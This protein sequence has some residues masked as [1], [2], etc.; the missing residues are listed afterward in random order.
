[1]VN[2]AWE[3]LWGIKLE[4]LTAYN[5]LEDKQL[6]EKGIMSYIK[7][8]FQGT[9]THIPAIKYEPNE[10][11]KDSTTVPFRWVEAVIYPIKD[12]AGKIIEIVLQHTDITE[13]KMM[14]DAL[15]KSEEKF[16]TLIENSSDAIAVV[17]EQGIITYI[18]ETVTHVLGYKPK[19]LMNKNIFEYIHPDDRAHLTEELGDIVKNKAQVTVQ[20][21]NLHKNGTW[22]WL[23]ATGVNYMDKPGINGILGNFRDITE[24]KLAE[25]EL[26]E[27]NQTLKTIIKASP[28]AVYVVDRTGKVILWSKVAEKMFGWSEKEVKGKVLPIVQSD[29]KVEFQELMDTLLKGKSFT[30]ETTR[31]HKDG[32]I[33]DVSISAAPVFDKNGEL[34]SIVAIT[35]D[36]TERKKTEEALRNSEERLRLAIEAGQIGVWDWDIKTNHISWSKKVYEIHGQSNERITDFTEYSKSIH[37]EDEERVQEAIDLALHK[38][39][40]YEIEFRILTPQGKVRWVFTKAQVIYKKGKAV[41]MLGATLDITDRKELERQKDEFISIASHELKTPL[42]SIKG[43]V[44]ILEKIIKE[45]NDQRLSNYINK[46]NVYINKLNTLISDLLDVS[47]IQA[48]KLQFSYDEYDF[49]EMVQESIDSFQPFSTQIKLIK[50]GSINTKVYGDRLRTEQVMN[51]FLSNAL[52]YAPESTEII[53]TLKLEGNYVTASVRDFGVGIPKDKLKNVFK[54]FYRVEETANQ[55]SGLGIG[56]YISSE[57]IKRQRGKIGVKREKDKGTTFFFS[58][59][60]DLRK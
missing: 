27:S 19:E 42:T 4:Q 24:R 12:E 35:S 8:G 51:N 53:I 36:I 44:Q 10:T 56:L 48:G 11:L 5:V 37:H 34:S 49:D 31:M 32:S 29:K 13:N 38:K 23:E 58:V 2:K 33:F 41:R 40:P 14:E 30:K 22:R 15:K 45:M 59:P 6:E 46:T 18:S 21:R 1:M 43:Y 20:Y 54:R 7:K 47:K 52:K 17:N 3:K 39:K 55:F 9:P 57:I 16:R 50:K 28:L 26:Y 25:S 60:V